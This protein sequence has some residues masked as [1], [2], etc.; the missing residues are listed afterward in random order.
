MEYIQLKT[1]LY[2]CHVMKDKVDMPSKKSQKGYG[3]A[4]HH[5]SIQDL[6]TIHKSYC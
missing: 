5:C 3:Q 1:H 6:N 4:H 2:G